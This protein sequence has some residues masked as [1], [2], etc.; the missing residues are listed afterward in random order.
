MKRICG[1]ALALAA[2][3]RP[4]MA[5]P[6]I[7]FGGEAPQVGHARVYDQTD[8]PVYRYE[9][10]NTFPHDTSDYTEALFM[11]DGLLYEGTGQYG[12]SRIA[13]WDLETSDLV[14]ERKLDS[15]YFGEG[16]VA[17][18]ERLYHLTYL[19]NTGFVYHHKTLALERTFHYSSQGWGLTTDGDSLIASNGSAA[20]Q[21]LDPDSLSV[22]RRII[23]RDGYSEIG[24]LNELEYV[25]GDIYANVWQTDFLVRFSAET[26]QV[27][28]WVDL[29]GLNPDPERLVYPHVLNGI[30]YDGEPG[31][32]IVTGK[33]WPS[34]WRIRLVPVAE[35]DRADLAREAGSDNQSPLAGRP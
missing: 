27:T 4:T 24:F 16:A 3:A 2:F 31:T 12:R 22:V 34:L 11:H 25:D 1:V 15:K 20:I 18:G 32:L 26:G 35:E 33:N 23:V 30:A 6:P 13:I 17:L 5:A 10:V 7:L 21:F 19:S 29:T 14:G 28:G 9:I 8:I